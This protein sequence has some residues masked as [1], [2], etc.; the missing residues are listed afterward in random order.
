MKFTQNDLKYENK[1]SL[2]ADFKNIKM[3]DLQLDHDSHLRNIDDDMSE[4][5]EHIKIHG[6]L[7]PLL[8]TQK[9][10]GK[11]EI[12][13]GFRRFKALNMLGWQNIPCMVVSETDEIIKKAMLFGKELTHNP[14]HEEDAIRICT[15]LYNQYCDP[16]IVAIKTGI[17]ERLVKRYVKFARLPKLLKDNLESIHKNPKTAVSIALDANDAL[18]WSPSSR[19]SEQK[20]YDLALKLGEKK[21]I[22]HDTYQRFQQAAEEH[23]EY[24]L[25]QIEEDS[26][27]I[28]TLKEYRVILDSNT[29]L[30]LDAFAEEHGLQPEDLLMNALNDYIAKNHSETND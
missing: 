29:S 15:E 3:M 5:V 18:G 9:D 13:S 28:R 8:V 21:K 24:S 26:E 14:L 25:E 12:I 4:L 7:E 10:N 19:I 30:H 6:L 17:S 1:I 2:V 22:S 20:V 23:P 16:K 27:K 11:Y